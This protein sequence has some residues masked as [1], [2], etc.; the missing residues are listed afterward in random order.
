MLQFHG[1]PRS[2]HA[3]ES[4]VVLYIQEVQGSNLSPETGY[5]D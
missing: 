4:K 2:L 3:K 1:F 5:S